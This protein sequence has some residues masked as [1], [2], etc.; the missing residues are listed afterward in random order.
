MDFGLISTVAP[1]GTTDLYLLVAALYIYLVSA[2]LF[3]GYIITKKEGL[4]KAGSIFMFLGLIPNT[5]A[6]FISWSE[7][8]RIPVA[9]MSEFANL[10]CWMAAALFLFLIWKFKQKVIGAFIAPLIFMTLY[11]SIYF[12]KGLDADL[13]PALQ[14]SWLTWHVI[15]AALGSGGFLV[16]AAVSVAYLVKEK[17]E[18]SKAT[19]G[20]VYKLLPSLEVLD[21]INYKT[22]SISYPLYTVGALFFGA[23]WAQYAWGTFWGWDPKEI[24]A[25]VIWIFYSAYLHARFRRGW[26]GRRAAWM[27]II[28]FI[29]VA[30]SFFGNNFLGGNHAYG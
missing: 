17:L 20:S 14:S 29:L 1:H 4:G 7:Q 3:I 8:G 21:E 12:Y 24:G 16:S 9:N 18:I 5:I 22:V 10:M 30:V 13:N 11:T 2:F 6:W 28:G 27:S 15:L 25:L 26:R 23:I 19:D